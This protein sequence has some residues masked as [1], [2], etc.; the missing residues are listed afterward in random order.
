MKFNPASNPFS[1]LSSVLG[2]ASV[3]KFVLLLFISM[4]S[5]IS[6][7]NAVHIFSS[8]LWYTQSGSGTGSSQLTYTI[9]LDVAYDCD[10]DRDEA[11][12]ARNIK[13]YRFPLSPNSQEF[14]EFELLPNIVS[15]P[16]FV[17]EGVACLGHLGCYKTVRYKKVWNPATFPGNNQNSQF[18]DW[19]V[20]ASTAG[21]SNAVQNII[22]PVILPEEGLTIVTNMVM[23]N[24]PRHLTYTN[25]QNDIYSFCVDDPNPSIDL[26]I[27][28]NNN[29]PCAGVTYEYEWDRIIRTDRYGERQPPDNNVFW[30]YRSP[31]NPIPR[32]FSLNRTT[33]ILS[34]SNTI[35]P[36]DGLDGAYMIGIKITQRVN[37]RITNIYRKNIAVIKLS[38][39]FQ[40][41]NIRLSQLIADPRFSSRFSNNTLDLRGLAFI[42]INGTLTIDRSLTIKDG[43]LRFSPIAKVLFNG[44]RDHVIE[45]DNTH[46]KCCENNAGLWEGVSADRG[47]F[48]LTNKSSIECATTGINA[49]GNLNIDSQKSDF[50]NNYTHILLTDVARNN[51]NVLSIKSTNFICPVPLQG[52]VNEYTHTGI[53]IDNSSVNNSP[54]INIG[55]G[56]RVEDRNLFSNI[57]QAD[58]QLFGTNATIKNCTFQ[59]E[60]VYNSLSLAT[61]TDYCIHV[62]TEEINNDRNNSPERKVI[63]DNCSFN[64]F[65]NGIYVD[66]RVAED[67]QGI[68]DR[69]SL[70]VSNCVFNNSITE[71][72]PPLAAIAAQ[73]QGILTQLSVK[74]CK[75]FTETGQELGRNIHNG[76]LCDGPAYDVDIQKNSIAGDNNPL[77]SFRGISIAESDDKVASTIKINIKQN[78]IDRFQVGINSYQKSDRVKTTISNHT[79]NGWGIRGAYWGIFVDGSQQLEVSSNTIGKV[80][81]QGYSTN[82]LFKNP[83]AGISVNNNTKPKIY[84]NIIENTTNPSA[85]AWRVGGQ[86]HGIAMNNSPQGEICNNLTKKLNYGISASGNCGTSILR[87]N[88]MEDNLS[89]LMCMWG[90]FFGFQYSSELVI[91]E[92]QRQN[93]DVVH[94]NKFIC[95]LP[96][97]NNRNRFTSTEVYS[98]DGNQTTF[99]TENSSPYNP[100][101]SGYVGAFFNGNAVRR[102]PIA[103]NWYRYYD[104]AN[105][106]TKQQGCLECTD[107]IVDFDPRD[108]NGFNRI[109]IMQL[110]EIAQNRVNF[111]PLY[112]ASQSYEAQLYLY[113]LLNGR[114][115]LRNRS[116]VLDSFYV[117]NQNSNL[118][119]ITYISDIVG[120]TADDPADNYNFTLAAQINQSIVP[121]NL[122]ES[123]YKKVFFVYND[124]GNTKTDSICPNK[125]R[126]LHEVGQQCSYMGG[127]PVSMARSLW[128]A[129]MHEPMDSVTECEPIRYDSSSIFVRAEEWPTAQKLFRKEFQCYP[130]PADESLSFRYAT[131]ETFELGIYNLTGTKLISLPLSQ[132]GEVSVSTA[133]LPAGIYLLQARGRNSILFNKKLIIVH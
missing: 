46:F 108:D 79:S 98:A 90:G 80:L 114:P 75:I 86:I 81:T 3:A 131:E 22:N 109:E 76:I 33:G 118:Q 69:I 110:E 32:N 101:A 73:G 58:I 126:L 55:L 36:F 15:E 121:Q 56:N 50:K 34:L 20:T 12:F 62:F 117:A 35:S 77:K 47:T 84:N 93:V 16:L 91:I 27:T 5:I 92:D 119:K 87:L 102:F 82:K 10:T 54:V 2:R 40:F 107:G 125:N 105:C 106:G 67:P 6:T 53:L 48:R 43:T 128:L 99:K 65:N 132:S 111:A 66:K 100:Y 11:N 97:P 74:D 7:V 18:Q 59:N 39:I 120:G 49:S 42:S 4:F 94:R 124:C 88:T 63:I 19:Y 104:G 13:I 21:Y 96:N 89:G 130:N 44:Q 38:C 133:E 113:G 64:R 123:N 17:R 78:A 95:N 37:G 28:C 83:H 71:Q 26:S 29:P 116:S 103:T 31:N 85:D 14:V 52:T 1:S 8:R 122:I 57:S 72:V 24:N 129:R 68:S 51:A 30:D 127:K 112:Q 9:Y 70:S 25:T 115:N 23:S 61:A 60:E 45:L 41:N